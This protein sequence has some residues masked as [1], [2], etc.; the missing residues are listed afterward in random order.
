MAY[1]DV[2]AGGS[3]Y[4]DGSNITA[5]APINAVVGK[6]ICD[7]AGN[8]GPAGAIVAARLIGAGAI[9]YSTAQIAA[10]S[11]TIA[12]GGSGATLVGRTADQEAVRASFGSTWIDW[13]YIGCAVD[14]GG[15]TSAGEAAFLTAWAPYGV[16]LTQ[17]SKPNDVTGG[18]VNLPGVLAAMTFDGVLI[19]A[20]NLTYGAGVGYARLADPAT[21]AAKLAYTNTTLNRMPSGA[22]RLKQDDP[23]MH[24]QVINC[25]LYTSDAADE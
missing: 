1:V 19:D 20:G 2:T 11:L 16:Q 4:T 24:N 21:F 23:G 15:T 10:V 5:G 9:L 7:V 3:G 22:R 6:V 8:I 17:N 14:S 25:L 18:G 13:T 12:G